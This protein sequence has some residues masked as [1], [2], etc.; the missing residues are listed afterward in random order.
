MK[1]TKVQ[2]IGITQK[3]LDF[4]SESPDGRRY[5][6]IIKFVYELKYGPGSYNANTVPIETHI[7]SDGF[8]YKTGGNSN[9]GYWSGAFKT[10]TMDDRSFGHLMKYII[11]NCD[12]NWIL[13]KSR[14]TT[15]ER[16]WAAENWRQYHN[17]CQ[18]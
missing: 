16:I 17:V 6:E 3:V 18:R 8:K 7:T 5:S 9:R 12:G 10:P 14:M 2:S 11:K 1:T 4:I 15:Q 13:R